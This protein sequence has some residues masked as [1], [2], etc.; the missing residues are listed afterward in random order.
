MTTS[1]YSQDQSSY[2]LDD[3][4]TE[5]ID[6]EVKKLK[7]D[8]GRQ[9]DLPLDLV[10][11][12]QMKSDLQK[13]I[14]NADESEGASPLNLALLSH[15]SFLPVLGNGYQSV[16]EM[17]QSVEP[18]V[19]QRND[20][21]LTKA[22]LEFKKKIA[23]T[24]KSN[25]ETLAMLEYFLLFSPSLLQFEE[26]SS[27]FLIRFLKSLTEMLQRFMAMVKKSSEEIW[28]VL[29]NPDAYYLRLRG[30]L[31]EFQRSHP[32]SGWMEYLLLIPDLFRLF[33]RLLLETRI[34]KESKLQVAAALAYLVS[35][36]DFIPEGFVGPIGYIDDAFVLC[37]TLS[38]MLQENRTGKGL[39]M[40]HW[41]GTEETL[42]HIM[43]VSKGFSENVDFFR[44]IYTWLQKSRTSV[45]A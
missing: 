36:I 42:D 45:S 18:V 40:E 4:S 12:E 39:L 41:A 11:F 28:A 24:S 14:K 26:E 35:P 17:I 44:G 7:S 5:Q 21:Q 19:E 20:S 25:S 32:N 13:L 9:I 27:S 29:K 6:L 16:G 22:F 30:E 34:S 23:K 37:A 33:V 3:I 43:E 15:S 31:H 38:D 1:I 2:V 10:P 8:I